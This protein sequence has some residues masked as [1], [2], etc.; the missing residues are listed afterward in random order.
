MGRRIAIAA[1]VVVCVLGCDGDVGGSGPAGEGASQVSAP[2]AGAGNP[3]AGAG[4]ATGG[5]SNPPS[6]GA[7][8][9]VTAR[10]GGE[11]ANTLADAALDA[12]EPSSPAPDAGSTPQA[13]A[14][15]AQVPVGRVPMFVA[16][17][18]VGR[19]IVSC[20]D[21]QHWLGNRSLETEGD[22]YA[23]GSTAAVTCF[24]DGLSCR[25]LRDGSCQTSGA[26]CDCDHHPG[27]GTGIA[28]GDGWFV[29]SW[30]WGPPGT[31]RRS[32][33]G[34]DWE[35][36]LM[37][38]SFGG[39]AYGQDRFVLGDRQPPLSSDHGAS[40]QQGGAA[41]LR[42][43]GVA[44][45]TIYN[46]R[47]LGFADVMGGRFVIAGESGEK[48]DVLIS[49]DAGASWWR[50]ASLPGEC[51]AGTRA[52]VGG[53]GVIAIVHRNGDVCYSSDG[54]D[55]FSLASTG[56][57]VESGALWTGQRFMAWGR[58][59]AYHSP[60]GAR[61]TVAATTPADFLP[62]P[63]AIDPGTRTIVAI[64]G[65]WQNWYARQQ[66]YRS[67]DGQQWTALDPSDVGSSAAQNHP[68]RHMTFGYATPS[69]LCP[70][71]P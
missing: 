20:D 59:Q 35:V 10:D 60:D 63:V 48:R 11:P 55:T 32:H 22:A 66:F 42:A 23:C 44:D 37:D 18:H 17:G 30:G 39:V 61:W 40:F 45:E 47:A 67:A 57:A 34:I 49:S 38:T 8:A 36:V 41:D 28:Y 5:A 52:I 50:P 9:A 26:S 31:V 24:Q 54:G 7:G 62:G 58:G 56:G 21:G 46:V 71:K 19:T 29:A 13:D 3:S 69:A 65:G 25:F 43:I 27:A 12:S 16:Q 15:P 53:G 6:A 2:S 68:M 70:A 51:A 64:R 4:N 14:A 33:D 1:L